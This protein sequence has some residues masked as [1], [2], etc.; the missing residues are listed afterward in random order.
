MSS[1]NVLNAGEV[2]R[3]VDDLARESASPELQRWLRGSA[4]RWILKHYDLYDRVRRDPATG[5]LRLVRPG[6][7][8][9]APPRAYAGEVPAWCRAALARG[10]DVVVLRLGASLRKR[11]GR[12]LALLADELAAGRLTGLERLT[13]EKVEE[14]VR[15][16][17]RDR[18]TARRRARI[19]RG[20]VPVLRTS[21][22]AGVVR[23]VSGESLSDEGSRMHHCVGGYHYPADV[24][25]GACEIY[26]LRDREGRPRATLE[27]EDDKVWQ[28]KGV[29][30][31]PVAAPDRVVLREFIRR[32][33]Y[34]AEGD[35]R[36]LTLYQRDFYCRDDEL[37]HH[38]QAG[39]GLK[40]L[41]E[42][43]FA[44]FATPTHAEVEILVCRLIANQWRLTAET[45]R[46]LYRAVRPEGGRTLR[47]SRVR[48]FVPYGIAVQLYRVALP[49]AFVNLTRFGVFRG[50]GRDAEARVLWRRL[51]SDLANL[52]LA[53]P[54]RLFALGPQL[55]GDTVPEG[56]RS[57]ATDVL[58][59]MAVD[60][61]RL[62]AERHAAL[63]RRLNQAKRRTLGR[64]AE[65]AKGHLA[66]R[67]LL[68]D[69]QGAFVL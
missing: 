52:A 47:L 61:S 49:M 66:V 60:V 51:E 40:L 28:V 38:L 44:G 65:P 17:R 13:F 69:R 15:K 9:E 63:R 62:R 3:F 36:N 30:N 54:V 55:C 27:V 18:Y 2:G 19:A 29:A 20:T 7:H 57:C 8:D 42:N 25:S 26:S 1:R 33:A 41:R 53:A 64:R 24:A 12:A 22:G 68:D 46:R 5:G 32:R 56:P 10:D 4:R 45:R 43:R 16:R 21:G 34:R 6:A 59:D 11:L 31:G 23:L 48:V 37:D 58:E 35:R 39:G 14:R 50:C 67:R